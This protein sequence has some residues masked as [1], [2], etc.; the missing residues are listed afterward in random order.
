MNMSDNNKFWDGYFKE[1]SEAPEYKASEDTSANEMPEM[2]EP[3]P[4]EVGEPVKKETPDYYDTSDIGPEKF[5]VDF[6]FDGVYRDVPAAKPFVPRREK[7]SGCVGGLLYGI[8]IICLSLVAAVL[9]WMAAVDVLALGK[10]DEEIILTL[11]EDAFYEGMVEVYDEEG[12]VTGEEP[13]QLA[14]LD[15]LAEVMYDSGLI[16]YK[17][18]FKIFCKFCDAETKVGAGT[19]TLNTKFDYRALIQGTTPLLKLP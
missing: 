6:D 5:K 16:K 19:Y 8:F 18:L 12:N 17:G 3:V 13:A 4:E 1:E 15:R 10:S 7:R 11:P 9:L 14:D 2:Q